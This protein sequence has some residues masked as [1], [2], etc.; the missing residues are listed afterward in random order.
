MC[1]IGSISGGIKVSDLI[2]GGVVVQYLEKLLNLVHYPSRSIFG[3]LSEAKIF[4][5]FCD[6]IYDQIIGGITW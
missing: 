5:F 6:E 4:N 1:G 3:A 2:F